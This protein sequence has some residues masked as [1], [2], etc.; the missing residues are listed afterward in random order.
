MKKVLCLCL[1]IVVLMS[2]IVGCGNTDK[3]KGD[4]PPVVSTEKDINEESNETAI[5]T[6]KENI[7]ASTPEQSSPA[8]KPA[9]K[10][11]DN[12]SN[13][14]NAK[15]A[16]YIITDGGTAE[17]S[18]CYHLD[19]CKQLKGTEHQIMEWEFVKTLAF[20]QCQTCKP[21]KYEGYIE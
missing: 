19:G 10:P 12:N 8:N 4:E 11:D 16:T 7:T 9:K 13:K 18:I 15:P 20:R 1:V 5:Q 6:E 21:P 2:V 14:N 3:G 17:S